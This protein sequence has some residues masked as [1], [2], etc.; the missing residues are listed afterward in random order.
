MAEYWGEVIHVYCFS[1]GWH[2][3]SRGQ[4][5]L[6]HGSAMASDLLKFFAVPRSKFSQCVSSAVWC[7]V[8]GTS[9]LALA[10]VDL[11]PANAYH[12]T[13]T[14]P[15]MSEAWNAIQVHIKEPASS[16]YSV[17]LH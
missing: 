6:V 14:W 2:G 10:F 1:V 17:T 7:M 5:S 9:L 13:M 4:K 11:P 12:I 16:R 3:R 8:K 15:K